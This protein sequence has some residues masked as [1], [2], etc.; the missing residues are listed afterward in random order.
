MGYTKFLPFARGEE[1]CVYKVIVDGQLCALKF[2]HESGR[3]TMEDEFIAMSVLE[4]VEGVLLP[5]APLGYIPFSDDIMFPVDFCAMVLPLGT[6][7]PDWFRSCARSCLQPALAQ[8]AQKLWA[9]LQ[10]VHSLDIIHRDV[11]P[12]NIIVLS[13][14]VTSSGQCA[15]IDVRLGDF[16]CAWF[17]D[18]YPQSWRGPVYFEGSRLYASRSALMGEV[19]CPTHDLVSLIYS[20]FS[21]AHPDEIGKGKKP[22]LE[23]VLDRCTGEEWCAFLQS[24]LYSIGHC[25]MDGNEENHSQN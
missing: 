15:S 17:R 5:V 16:G 20:L 24:E 2:A 9:T 8:L 1:A 13:E 18:I 14:P 22:A 10:R 12:D 25:A 19:P 23:V 21:L 7:L 3:H 4:D 11:K 6:A